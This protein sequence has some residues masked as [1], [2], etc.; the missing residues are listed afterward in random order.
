[1]SKQAFDKL[2]GQLPEEDKKTIYATAAAYG[3]DFEAPEWIP[4][5]IS[6]HGLIAIQHAIDDLGVAIQ[7]GSDYAIREAMKTI[8]AAR[9]AEVA[10]LDH[11][12]ANIESKLAK[13]VANGRQD[14]EAEAVKISAQLTEKLTRT[15]QATAA[16]IISRQ[17]GPLNTAADRTNAAA[18][19]VRQAA[20]WLGLKTMAFAAVMIVVVSL[21]AWGFV[22]WERNE[23]DALT[24]QQAALQTQIAQEQATVAVLDKRH[25]KV[26]WT[27]CGGRLCFEVNSNQGYAQDGSTIKINGSWSDHNG[28][29]QYVIP[30]G[31]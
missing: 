2:M 31:Y 5:A 28:K 25:G 4:F 15:L 10:N 12:A 1:M 16:D 21:A 18:E 19:Q 11:A 3:L 20:Q 6:Q 24:A 8:R 30:D 23:V 26:Q 29:N 13:T 14:L 22:A 27:D 7:T 9:D 17:V